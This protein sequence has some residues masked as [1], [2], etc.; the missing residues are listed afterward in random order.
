MAGEDCRNRSGGRRRIGAGILGINQ[1][2]V[3]VEG[4]ED[5]A[6]AS[7]I[8]DAEADVKLEGIEILGEQVGEVIE[9]VFCGGEAE[10]EEDGAREVFRERAEPEPDSGE[11]IWAMWAGVTRG[12]ILGV[13]GIRRRADKVAVE[14]AFSDSGGRE[15]GSREG[16]I[17]TALTEESMWPDGEEDRGIQEK[18][19]I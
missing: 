1:G 12:S 17:L 3:W 18:R 10:F 7:S 6:P 14:E 19:R 4:E 16:G 5:F 15:D 9:E 2:R 11:T 13:D 8:E